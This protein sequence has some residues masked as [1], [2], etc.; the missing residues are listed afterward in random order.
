MNPICVGVIGFGRTT[1]TG[2]ASREEGIAEVSE[3]EQV[4]VARAGVGAEMKR[5]RHRG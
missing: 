3:P 4:W 5:H 2:S 1:W